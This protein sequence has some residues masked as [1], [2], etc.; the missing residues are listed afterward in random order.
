MADERIN[1]AAKPSGDGCVECDV[2]NGWWLHLRRC[3][4]CGHIG[5]CD[6][7]PSQHASAHA[8]QKGHEIVRSFEP[9]EDWFWDY[10]TEHTTTGPS[11]R[12]PNIIRS[13]SPHQAL[14][15]ASRRTGSSTCTDVH[16]AGP[17]LRSPGRRDVVR[18]P[19]SCNQANGPTE[20][21]ADS[22]RR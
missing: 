7:S 17:S 6:S 16:Q 1:Q 4:A 11:W 21:L 9:G 19:V 2:V 15:A 14:P 20:P 3:A 8:R 12:R 5:C 13:A 18:T 10:E 22:D